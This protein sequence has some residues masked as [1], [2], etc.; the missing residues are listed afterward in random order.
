M[1]SLRFLNG[2]LGTLIFSASIALL[3]SCGQRSE[4]DLPTEGGA[5]T[6][7]VKSSSGGDVPDRDIFIPNTISE[8]A[9]KVLAMGKEAKA[10]KKIYPASDDTAGWRRVRADME[11]NA[12][13]NN[14]KVAEANEVTVTD[15]LIGGVKVLDLRP[16]GWIENG[17][18]I[19][20]CHGGAYTLNS[21]RTGIVHAAPLAKTSGMRILSVDYTT[22]PNA[23]WKQIQQEVVEVF[24]ALLAQGFKLKNMGIY[25]ASA[26]GGL[27]TSTVLNLRD[28]GLGMPAAVVLW[29]PWVDLTKDG[30][31]QTTLEDQEP[32]L[33]YNGLLDRSAKAFAAGLDLKDPK[34]SPMHA[35]FNKGFPPTLIQEGT[36]TIFLSTSIRLYQRLDEA[37]QKPVIDMYEGMVHVFQQLPIPEAEYAV[38]KTAKFFEEH[39]K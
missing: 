12:L 24:K 20:F 36:K 16:K 30:D 18:R 34:V 6:G 15:T 32:M 31:T 33:L 13:E 17:K 2:P 29:S 28:Q 5:E 19:V 4:S 10:Y 27:A 8:A 3:T 26:G 38:K 37:G 23:N 11:A 35:D 21:A 25:G 9:Q 14:R 22:A 1:R 39:L 7:K